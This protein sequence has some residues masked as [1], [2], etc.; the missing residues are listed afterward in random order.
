MKGI[1]K[2]YKLAPLKHLIRFTAFSFGYLKQHYQMLNLKDG[3]SKSKV[4]I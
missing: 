1:I 3:A 2:T 4:K